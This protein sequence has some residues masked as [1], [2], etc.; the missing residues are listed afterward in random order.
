MQK[1]IDL[2]RKMQSP[3][4]SSSPQYQ[5]ET[6][7]EHILEESNQVYDQ[8]IEWLLERRPL[9]YDPAQMII[10]YGAEEAEAIQTAFK[11]AFITLQG[12]KFSL[13]PFLA[14]INQ[15]GCGTR[16]QHFLAWLQSGE[17]EPS[18]E[19]LGSNERLVKEAFAGYARHLGRVVSYRALALLDHQFKTIQQD[20]CINP[21]GR[22]KTDEATLIRVVNAN[23][24]KKVLYARLYIG[25]RLLPYD[26]SVSLHD[27]G[28]T[29]V[30]IANGY[31]ELPHRRI[32]LMK[33]T[34]PKIEAMGYTVA[35]VQDPSA[36]QRWF[37]H[38]HI[39]FDSLDERTERYVLWGVPFLSKRLVN[40]RIFNSEE[41]VQTYL[42]PFQQRQLKAKQNTEEQKMS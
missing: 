42:L 28:E 36:K 25:L 23:G 30:C 10:D 13:S 32:H 20:D 17:W 24:V 37:K 22:L 21:S 1:T 39:W 35:Q 19:A 4:S 7:P 40:L 27:D 18:A 26:P 12:E 34:V 3:S 9:I 8:E 16:W 41:E 31:A 14:C 6:M 5:N 15:P 2:Y 33:V 29:A 11:S 38:R